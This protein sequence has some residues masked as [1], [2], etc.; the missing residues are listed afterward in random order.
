[1]TVPYRSSSLHLL[2]CLQARALKNQT[3]T[4]AAQGADLNFKLQTAKQKAANLRGQIVE[5]DICAC[6]VL[7]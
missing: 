3:N 4:Y 6:V 1:M 7:I 5:V 2:S